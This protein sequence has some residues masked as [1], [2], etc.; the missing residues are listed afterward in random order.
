MGAYAEEMIAL[1]RRHA[2]GENVSAEIKQ[3]QASIDI[4]AA[5]IKGLRSEIK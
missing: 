4:V 2:R 5:L 1:S 3:V